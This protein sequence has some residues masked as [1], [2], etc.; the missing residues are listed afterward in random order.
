MAKGRL[1]KPFRR[2]FILT[3]CQ[4]KFIQAA[5][6]PYSSRISE[7][8]IRPLRQNIN[9]LFF[10]ILSNIGHLKTFISDGLLYDIM[11]ANP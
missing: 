10:E 1:K 11:Q 7:P 3:G 5:G 2:P 9:I 6:K 4:F 8:D